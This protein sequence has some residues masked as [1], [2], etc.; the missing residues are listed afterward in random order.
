[1]QEKLVDLEGRSRKN[2]IRIYGVPEEK[3][4]N[5]MFD[6]VEQFLKIEL[7]LAP[8]TNLQIQRAHRALARKPER[9][10]P[11]R[12]ILATTEIV[13]RRKVYTGIKRA[14]K[15]KGIRFQTP[16]D[17]MRIHYDLGTRTYDSAQ[18]AVRELRRRGYSV[19]M[20]VNSTTELE[21]RLQA[22]TWQCVGERDEDGNEAAR[23]ARERLQEFQRIPSN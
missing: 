13:Q 10:A 18:D 15:E 21:C 6:F 1:M 19:E 20:P 8:D 14:L 9:N 17:K 3:E 4:G 2:T 5:S 7:A 11:P 22:K 12:S 16:L 23:R